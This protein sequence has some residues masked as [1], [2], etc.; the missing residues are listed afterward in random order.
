MASTL[1]VITLPKSSN[2]KPETDNQTIL[3]TACHN[4][5]KC[6]CI[7][8]AI[9]KHDS[10]WAT[11]GIGKKVNNPGNMRP[12]RT[13]KPSVPFTIYNAKGNG[14]FAHFQT[15][16]DGIIANVELYQRNYA[17]Y[18]TANA[19]VS[20]WAGGGGNSE[21]RRAVANCF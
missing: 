6:I 9:Y 12:P 7:N 10:S 20:V 21:Y 17:K 1:T 16:E 4:D 14:Q 13:W 15:L 18:E 3:R 19:L 11:A 5:E 2:S 8:N